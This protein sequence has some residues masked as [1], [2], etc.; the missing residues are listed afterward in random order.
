MLFT[1]RCYEGHDSCDAELWYHTGQEC[2]ILYRL[3]SDIIDVTEVGYMYKVRF[4]DRLEYDV[5]E[6]ELIT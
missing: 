6:D 3:P 4:A 1:Y 5:F 2:T